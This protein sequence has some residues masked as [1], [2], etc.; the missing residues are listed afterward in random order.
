MPLKSLPQLGDSNWGT[1]LNAHISQLQNPS[2]GAINS[3]EQFS[4]RP[5]NLTPDDA[6]KTYLYTQTGNIHQW[7]GTAWKVLNES[8]INVKD[9][10]AVGDGVA[11]DYQAF[12][13][14]LNLL[15]NNLP[16]GDGTKIGGQLFVPKG[17]YRITQ[18]IV[19]GNIA[20]LVIAGE[21]C[22]ISFNSKEYSLA[23]VLINDTNQD[24]IRVNR[25]GGGILPAHLN[26]RDLSIEQ[27]NNT[28][29]IGINVLLSN[30]RTKFSKISILNGKYGIKV[31]EIGGN[32]DLFPFD[33]YFEDIDI[34]GEGSQINLPVDVGIY[35]GKVGS[36]FFKNIWVL[37]A[38]TGMKHAYNSSDDFAQQI[39][40]DTFVTE[41]IQFESLDLRAIQK[42]AIRNCHFENSGIANDPSIHYAVRLG[43]PDSTDPLLN[44]TTFIIRSTIFALAQNGVLIEGNFGSGELSGITSTTYMNRLIK[45]KSN[46]TSSKGSFVISNCVI[47]GQVDVTEYNGRLLQ[48][49]NTNF[50]QEALNDGQLNSMSLSQK[51]K[52]SPFQFKVGESRTNIIAEEN[53]IGFSKGA[54]NTGFDSSRVMTINMDNLSNKRGVSLT[55]DYFNSE[56]LLTHNGG[57]FGTGIQSTNQINTNPAVL[58]LNKNGGNVGI[59]S[60][61]PTSKLQVTGLPIHANNVTAIQNGLT[62]G[63]FYHN[64]DGI[65]RVVF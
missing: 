21:S 27:K 52:F 18:T 12:V 16:G 42:V 28:N 4:G 24:L 44:N 10:G 35:L 32:K 56:L 14:C 57:G 38:G 39:T 47:P 64:G 63:A 17:R 22:G 49:N 30:G 20:G 58:T 13:K 5:T 36:L 41:R 50:A 26:I 8:V 61:Y 53:I 59:G 6:G 31:G 25:V 2:N 33:V 40:I 54:Q 11:D 29:N 7:N 48:F 55:S 1:P 3:F 34:T 19:I 15:G 51:T 45:I 62:A 9:Y 23:S 37:N 46:Q 65:L 60:S 43:M